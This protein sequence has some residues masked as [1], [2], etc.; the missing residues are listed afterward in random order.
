MRSLDL[1]RFLWLE[2]KGVLGRENRQTSARIHPDGPTSPHIRVI[3]GVAFLLMAPP[4]ATWAGSQ[5]A[6]LARHEVNFVRDYEE[7]IGEIRLING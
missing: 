1:K 6:I 3:N 7:G 4:G 2:G 5:E